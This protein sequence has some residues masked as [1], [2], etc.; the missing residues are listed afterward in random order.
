MSEMY[1]SGEE[2]QVLLRIEAESFTVAP[3]GSL[4]IPIVLINEGATPQTIELAVRGVPSIWMF[5]PSQVVRVAAGEERE[6]PLTV[7]PP[8]PPQGRAGLYTL[9]VRAANQAQ[10]QERAEVESTLT[11]AALEVPGR[12]GVLM[13]ATEFPVAPGDSVTI[14][15]VLVNRGVDGDIFQLSVAEIPSGWVYTAAPSTR[16]APGQAQEVSLTVQPPRGP[17]TRAGRHPF[18]IQVQSQAVPGQVA[19]AACHLTIASFVEFSSE[20]RP[21]QVAAGEPAQVVIENRGNIPQVFGV[22]WQSPDQGLVFEP[23]PTQELRVAPGEVA[24]AA[25]SASPRSRP[26]IGGE[27]NYPF[28]ARVQTADQEAKN[29]RGRVNSRAILPSWVVPA[30]VVV[31]LLLIGLPLLFSWLGDRDTA[32]PPQ[33]TP[34]AEVTPVPTEAPAVPTEPPPLPTE[35]PPE[36]PTEPPPEVPTEPP[37]EVPTEVPPEVTAEQ[38]PAPTEVPEEGG[39]ICSAAA[40]GLLLVPLFVISKT[41]RLIR[42]GQK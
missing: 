2:S 25:Y 15:L 21:E 27:V 16:L 5:M 40:L 38:P 34:I 31:I 14:P 28:T 41:P 7:Q 37:A 9:V 29:L 30:G 17:Q 6:V 12:I 18:E 20:L 11:V 23:A 35:P 1:L 39:G 4:T 32:T 3:G 22:S 26:L 33:D 10:P 42:R 19:K 13:A 8:G 36:A 24:A